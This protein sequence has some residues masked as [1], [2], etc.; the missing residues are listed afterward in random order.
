MCVRFV[1]PLNVKMVSHSVGVCMCAG[2]FHAFYSVAAMC[3]VCTSCAL[4]W[5]RTKLCDERAMLCKMKVKF[6]LNNNQCF[7]LDCACVHVERTRL[8]TA[9]DHHLSP[10]FCMSKPTHTHTLIRINKHACVRIT[11]FFLANNKKEP[12][13]PFKKKGM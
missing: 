4:Q 6:Q 13:F 9:L 1:K 8:G 5:A 3:I 12:L 2:W 10:L 11:I 7:V